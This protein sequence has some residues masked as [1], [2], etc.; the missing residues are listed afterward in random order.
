MQQFDLEEYLKNTERQI[1][2]KVG[3]VMTMVGLRLV[4]MV[5]SATSSCIMQ[6]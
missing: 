4:L 3:I 6:V 5:L 1:V 2:T